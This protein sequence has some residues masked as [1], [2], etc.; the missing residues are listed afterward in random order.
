MAAL[1]AADGGWGETNDSYIDPKLGGTNGGESTSNFTAWA[2]AQM[3]FGDCESDSVKRGI[4]YL[5][6]VQQEDGFWWHRSHNAPGFPRIFYLKYHGYT[7]Y[8][9][10][11]ARALSAAGGAAA[12]RASA[13]PGATAVK[14]A[15][16][17][18]A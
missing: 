14:A 11:G 8:F 3:A 6:S 5:L 9:P 10:L 1:A 16:T 2:L 17:V 13:A 12:A 7:A 18:L 15:A 4:A